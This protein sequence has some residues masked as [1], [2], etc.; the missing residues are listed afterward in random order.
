M[1]PVWP[2]H[3]FEALLPG[4]CG[5]TARRCRTTAFASCWFSIDDLDA[6]PRR[7]NYIACCRVSGV[8]NL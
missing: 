7:A 2:L 5:L 1:R 3:S 8:S 4:A 6:L